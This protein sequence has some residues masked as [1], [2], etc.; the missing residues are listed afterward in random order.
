MRNSHAPTSS[1]A[2]LFYKFMVK[3]HSGKIFSLVLLTIILNVLAFYRP[4]AL[5]N[6]LNVG[7]S[8]S[9]D[10][11]DGYIFILY[12][13]IFEIIRTLFQEVK[14]IKHI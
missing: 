9:N 7:K 12:Y 1:V 3:L 11:S 5:E 6:L 4:I 13:V 2:Y 8:V 10:G 14:T